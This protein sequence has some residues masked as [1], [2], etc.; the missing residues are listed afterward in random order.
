MRLSEVYLGLGEEN[1][2]ALLRGISLGRLRTY[3]LF[4]RLK[5]RLR[6]NKLNAETLRRSA[7]RV[8]PRLEEGDE[9]LAAELAQAILV[10]HFD[11]IVAVL[12]Y[13]KIPHQDGFFAK[14]IDASAHLTEGWQDRVMAEFSGKFDRTALLFYVNH[15]GWELTKPASVYKPAA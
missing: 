3:Q 14:E 6:L 7:L 5:L 12:D 8:W 10:S 1:L 2:H 11:I 13:L 15:L 4:E 9:E